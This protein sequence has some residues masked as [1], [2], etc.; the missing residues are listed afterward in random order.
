MRPNNFFHRL[1]VAFSDSTPAFRPKSHP[2][3]DVSRRRLLVAFSDATPAF[4]EVPLRHR[5]RPARRLLSAFADPKSLME[6]LERA[7]GRLGSAARNLARPVKGSRLLYHSSSKIALRAPSDEYVLATSE[8]SFRFSWHALQGMG[9]EVAALLLNP[10]DN[11]H[12]AD[13]LVF[14][15]NISSHDR[16][17]QRTAHG[18]PF[19]RYNQ[20]KVNLR[21]VSHDHVKIIFVV[22][23]HHYSESPT[24]L[25]STSIRMAEETTGKELARMR[26]P[27]RFRHDSAIIGEI[28]RVTRNAW[29]FKA[30]E[31]EMPVH[32]LD[33][34][35]RIENS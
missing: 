28:F 25:G 16:S 24:S 34:L 17:V 11:I 26:V 7:R 12:S 2:S 32:I 20:F 6:S 19:I 21:H 35:R 15:H 1:L 29:C 18:S 30:G 13:D 9:I 23:F 31:G 5:D 10:G 33:L 22:L 4:Q 14:D 8:P 27:G 3:V